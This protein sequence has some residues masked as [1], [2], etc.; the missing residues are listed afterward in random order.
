MA[1]WGELVSIYLLPE[2]FG[3][4]CG[5]PLL[6]HATNALFEKGF[7]HVYLWVLQANRRAQKFYEQQDFY[8]NGDTCSI[9][10]EGKKLTEI[11]Y[12]KTL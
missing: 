10:I 5:A 3:K 2:Y 8:P 7:Q 12:V 9:E 4:G 6:T 1:G 11:R